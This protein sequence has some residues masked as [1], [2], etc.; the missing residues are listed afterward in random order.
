MLLAKP[1]MK[2]W[3]LAPYLKA[4]VEKW[5]EKS[6]ALLREELSPST[7]ADDEGTTHH[8]EVTLLENKQEYVHVC[9]PVCSEH[10]PGSCYHPLSAD[11]LVYRDDYVEK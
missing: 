2:C 10:V 9:V 4:K 6:C 11:F 8:V 1:S 5:S 3:E 7:Y